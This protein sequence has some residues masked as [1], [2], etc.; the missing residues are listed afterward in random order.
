MERYT[1][2]TYFIRTFGC[3]ANTAD[4]NNLAG[5]LESLGFEPVVEP[6]DSQNERDA[7][8]EFLPDVDV[9]ILNTCSVRQ[10]SEDKV[11]GLGKILK[12]LSSRGKKKPFIVM[13]GCM[14]GSVTGE[15]QRY[16]FEELQKK[17]PWVDLY[18][19]PSQVFDLPNLLLEKGI[20]DEWAVKK[21]NAAEIKPVLNDKRSAFVN[22][23]YGCDNFCTFCVVP[24]A[25]GAEVSRPE[26]EI[27]AEINHLVIRGI[28]DFTLCGQNVNSWGL[29]RKTKFQV[30]TGSN[31]KLPFADLLRKVHEIEGVKKINFLSSNPFDFTADLL[32]AIT[33]PK[34]D[35]YL[36]IAVQS[37]NNEV[38]KNMNR[39]HTIEDFYALVEKI[40][41]AKP[42]VELGTD[43]IVGFPGETEAQF[44]D[45]VELF[46][47]VKFN[48]A[49][50]SIYSVRKGTN[51]DK[52][53]PDDIPLEE[54]KRRHAYL[55]KVW[56]ESL[57]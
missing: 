41:E 18:M 6:K 27:L 30:R 34:I 49:F 43:I 54:K 26:N 21:Y 35:N 44:M 39:R 28:T 53:Y 31:D 12:E 37:G 29:D 7:Y 24:Y 9:F 42:N 10:K 57:K 4:S 50:I 56:K 11:Y 22:I 5:I 23:S 55:T 15:R 13:A 51:A 40:K 25:R 52:F 33:L 3:Q 16:A 8:L 48:V 19:N 46:N 47:K 32:D 38:L 20:L 45:T 1:P 17:T 36:H 2:K 14:V